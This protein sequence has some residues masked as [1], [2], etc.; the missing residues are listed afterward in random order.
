MNKHSFGGNWTVEK[1]NILSEYLDFYITALKNQTF[2]KIYID[3]FAGTGYINIGDEAE[4]IEGSVKLALKVT[5]PFDK[6]IFI[7]KNND[8]AKELSNMVNNEFPHA[9]H[10]VCIKNEDCNTALKDICEKTD[11]RKNRALMFLDPYATELEWETLKIIAATRAIDVW[12]LFPLS[13][14]NRML[15][16][17]GRIQESWRDK[18]NKIFGDDGW[19]EEFYKP[20]M[21]MSLFDEGQRFNKKVNE[22]QLKKYI[23]GRLKTIFPAVADNPRILYNTKNSPLFLFCFAVSNNS[24]TAI[25]LALNG[26]DHILEYCGK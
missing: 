16:K 15:K 4:V 26:A 7:E 12:Y 11:W 10:R 22:L 18:L 8:Y 20:D 25:R 3:A 14:A 17:D 19:F 5:N 24:H 9:L 21:Q 23:Y 2:K 6:Y 13:A 1:L